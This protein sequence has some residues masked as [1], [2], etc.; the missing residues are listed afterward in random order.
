MK[1]RSRRQSFLGE[2]SDEVLADTTIGIVGA[3]GGGTPIAQAAAHIGFGTTHLFDPDFA[4]EHH[5]HRLIGISSAAV[6]HK[7]KKVRVAQR[8]MSRVHPEGCVVPHACNWQEAHEVLRSC[9]IVFSCVDGYLVRDELERYLRRFHVPLIDIGMD[10]TR[11][12]SG[13]TIYGQAIL[14]LPGRHCMRCFGLIRDELLQE[15]AG[16]YGDAGARAQVIWPNAALASTAIGMAMGLLLPWHSALAIAPYLVYDGNRLEI[17]PSPRLKHLQDLSCRHY[18]GS[19]RTGDVMFV[20]S[21]G[22]L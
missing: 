18:D 3:S 6:K 16:R 21:R 8:L 22:N 19:Q 14:S 10:V 20:G 5:R 17:A 9:D 4:E 1:E 2:Q 13:Y 12:E 7:W 15:E 11:H